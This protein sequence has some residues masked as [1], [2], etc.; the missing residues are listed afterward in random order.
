MSPVF[1]EL[2]HE[3]MRDYTA[4]WDVK[5]RGATLEIITPH[6]TV[7]DKVVSVFITQ[8]D[9]EIIISDGG[10]LHTGAYVEEEAIE[11]NRCYNQL[12]SY[13]ESYYNIQ[14]VTDRNDKLI[15]YLKNSKMELVTSCIHDMAS[16][17]TGVVNAQ[18]V[19]LFTD[20]ETI[21]KARFAKKA[22][23]FISDA[24]AGR[25]IKF[26]QPLRNDDRI[27]FSAG[28][29]RGTKVGLVQFI[30]GS[31]PYHL[32]SS[33]TKA[34]VNFQAITGSALEPAVE[35]RVSL[36]DT[37]AEGIRKGGNSTYLHL[38]SSVSEVVPWEDRGRLVEMGL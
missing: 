20:Q 13:Y 8:R 1:E 28:V 16:F 27:R 29:W 12:V 32:G 15:F 6:S 36:L 34:T 2:Y 11:S 33:M 25:R 37:S 5:V 18:Q 9:G 31:D 30:T 22:G 35:H 26:A 38:L 10:Y 17:I 23:S 7:S 19:A 21:T 3:V 4:L 24:F 14:R